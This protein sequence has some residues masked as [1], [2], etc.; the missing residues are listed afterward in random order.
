[1][2]TGFE[3]SET[4]HPNDDGSTSWPEQGAIETYF[5]DCAPDVARAAARRLRRQFWKPVQEVTP[6]VRW[7]AAPSAYVIARDDRAV[8]PAYLRQIARER[9]GIE[10]V[11]IGGGHSPFLSR[12]EELAA[13]LVTLAETS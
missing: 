3:A 6:L 10:P 11:E 9:F 8:A 2:G 1:M 4:P 12:P 7:P 5:H 13:L